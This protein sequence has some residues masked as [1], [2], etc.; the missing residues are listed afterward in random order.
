[1]E[2]ADVESN[3]E[4]PSAMPLS[5]FVSAASLARSLIIST[6]SR[7]SA[8]AGPAGLDASIGSRVP[9][10][11]NSRGGSAANPRLSMQGQAQLVGLPQRPWPSTAQQNVASMVSQ[12]I[13]DIETDL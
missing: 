1:M 4:I 10:W 12:K 3:R 5:D 2:I 6:C 9:W 11:L 13:R 8:L 7:A